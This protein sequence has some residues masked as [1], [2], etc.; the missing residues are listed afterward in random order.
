MLAGMINTLAYL[1]SAGTPFPWTPIKF[2]LK[3]NHLFL[4][5]QVRLDLYLAGVIIKGAIR[6]W[7]APL[8]DFL[9]EEESLKDLSHTIKVTNL[10]LN[11]FN[12]LFFKS[13]KFIIS[14]HKPTHP[15]HS[16]NFV[17]A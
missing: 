17:P 16:F 1:S 8:K 2:V 9:R 5:S 4:S 10:C 15:S 13:F 14:D 7:K 11:I 6:G 12:I 3:V